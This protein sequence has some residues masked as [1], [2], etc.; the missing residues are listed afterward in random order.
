MSAKRPGQRWKKSKNAPDDCRWCWSERPL[1]LAGSSFSAAAT[2]E[3]AIALCPIDAVDEETRLSVSRRT[4]RLDRC[5]Q[6]PPVARDFH[7]DD[8]W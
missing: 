1:L 3:S 4:K 5:Q 2:T 7:Y 6:T 8:F